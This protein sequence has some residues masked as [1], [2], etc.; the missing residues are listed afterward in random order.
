MRISWP[1]DPDWP[2]A[3]ANDAFRWNDYV[4]VKLTAILDGWLRLGFKEAS[5]LQQ[6]IRHSLKASVTG[7]TD[8]PSAYGVERLAILGIKQK[9]FTFVATLCHSIAPFCQSS[10][11]PDL[12]RG[13]V[14]LRAVRSV[15]AFGAADM[16]RRG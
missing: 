13:S 7:S 11:M 12:T 2:K 10:P 3:T 4:V 1:T 16:S 5:L 9:R 8:K 15:S 14:R 6:M